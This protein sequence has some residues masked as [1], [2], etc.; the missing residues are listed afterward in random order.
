LKYHRF[1]TRISILFFLV[2]LISPAFSQ[3]QISGP[4]TTVPGSQLI[5]YFDLVVNDAGYV[6]IKN[7]GLS[8]I[9]LH[10]QVFAAD[11][12]E[13]FD[14]LIS[15]EPL[16]SRTFDLRHFEYN[17][18]GGSADLIGERGMIFVTPTTPSL[19]YAAIPYNKMI[20]S[21]V[22]ANSRTK[23]SYGMNAIARM[24]VDI[25]GNPLP[26]SVT[27]MNGN[28]TGQFQIIRPK[29]IHLDRFFA[30][31][32]ITDSRLAFVSFVDLYSDF[33]YNLSSTL[34]EIKIH[35]TAG[36]E[37]CVKLSLPNFSV[38]CILD[39]ALRTVVG[40]TSAYFNQSSGSLELTPTYNQ[41]SDDFPVTND[42]I[43]NQNLFGFFFE[44]LGSYASAR[45][46]WVTPETKIT[47]K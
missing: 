46:L 18:Q 13:L 37:D 38:F 6:S 40:A 30:L 25:N 19:G 3:T 47:G 41:P 44:T 23:T 43:K 45:P 4:N 29:M 27:P 1:A 9:F 22:I 35:V 21:I 7:T 10:I 26:D 31:N 14:F 34:E 39:I 42:Y 11:C 28:T 32:T 24:A 15:L 8:T 16:C 17:R 33:S 12:T 5:F 36:T 2:L 20:G